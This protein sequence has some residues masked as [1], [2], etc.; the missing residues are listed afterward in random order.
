MLSGWRMMNEKLHKT[1]SGT[2]TTT[3]F[4]YLSSGHR[5]NSQSLQWPKAFFSHFAAETKHCTF[6][7]MLTMPTLYFY[8]GHA[9]VVLQLEHTFFIKRKTEVKRP[10]RLKE[11]KMLQYLLSQKNHLVINFNLIWTTLSGKSMQWKRHNEKS[12]NIVF[13]I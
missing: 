6:I 13:H 1:A 2:Y 4:Y 8:F 12:W 11:K 7:F 10:S 9:P 5:T 3:T